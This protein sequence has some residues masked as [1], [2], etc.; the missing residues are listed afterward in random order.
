MDKRL[1][2]PSDESGSASEN[3]R[4][5]RS[6]WQK[7]VLKVFDK[8]K[9]HTEPYEMQAGKFQ[10]TI[11]PNVFS[12]KYFTDSLWF[13]ETLPKLVGRKR[14][15]EVGCGTGIV[16]LYCADAGAAVTATDINPEASKNTELNAWKNGLNISVRNGDM[17]TAIRDDEKFDVIFW[18]HPFN[19]WDKPVDE[20]LLRAGLDEQYA[21]LR[22]YVGEGAR[23][24]DEGGQLLLGTGD[25]AD[26]PE[27]ESIAAENGYRLVLLEKVDLPLEE[28]GNVLNSY[29]IYR[30]DR[31]EG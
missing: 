13:A 25:M 23:H 7:E 1:F 28:G 12:P 11:L 20:M 15:L 27:I 6:A 24:L 4:L 10:L 21:G 8:M 22:K 9:K 30:F 19:N 26:V 29:L 18:N 31:K 3:G 14:L 2:A 16:S 17:F 5:D